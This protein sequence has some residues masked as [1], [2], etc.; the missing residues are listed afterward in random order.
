MDFSAFDG[1]GMT[2]QIS[3]IGH[4]SMTVPEMAVCRRIIPSTYVVDKIIAA[5]PAFRYVKAF[6]WCLD[7]ACLE[8]L[9][10]VSKALVILIT[11]LL[12]VPIDTLSAYC[13]LHMKKQKVLL[14]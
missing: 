13:S 6:A 4:I 1:S 2:V 12:K 7:P 14:S 5:F 9:I 8:H 10:P 11:P 3:E